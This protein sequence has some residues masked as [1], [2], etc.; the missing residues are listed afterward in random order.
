MVRGVY[1]PYT[2]SGLKKKT[3]LCVSSLGA[4]RESLVCPSRPLKTRLT[5]FY[6]KKVENV[7][8]HKII[9]KC[10]LYKINY[11]FDEILMGG[12]ALKIKRKSLSLKLKCRKCRKEKLK[13]RKCRK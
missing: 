9:E 2:L 12:A 13:C 5:L 8:L 10:I 7:R 1:P 3:F 11:P 6:K 4:L